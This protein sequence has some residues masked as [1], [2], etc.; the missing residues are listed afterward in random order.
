[1]QKSL[2]L[3]LLF[4]LI[5]N[6]FSQSKYGNPEVNP[7]TIQNNFENWL[8]YQN[9]NVM[10]SKDFIAVDTNNTI[11]SKGSF[12][13]EL[14]QGNTIPIKLESNDSK[15][16]YKLFQIESNADSNIKATMAQNAFEEYEHFKMEGESFPKFNFSDLNGTIVSNETMKGKI[17]VIKC[18]YIHCPACIKEFPLVNELAKK[19]ENRK[20]I[21]FISLAEDTPEQLSAFLTKKPLSYLVI[22][23]MKTYMNETLHLN[24]F[25]THF[26]L[27]TQ[28]HISKVLLNYESL[29]EALQRESNK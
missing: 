26:I 17:V 29:E 23:N 7:T 3:F 28:G 13:N 19:Y 12:L 9:K 16:Y 1:M 24:S 22:P 20:D 18:W 25:P 2:S 5:I 15:C 10:L 6:T 8:N 21:L 27:D 4:F 11:I 14:T